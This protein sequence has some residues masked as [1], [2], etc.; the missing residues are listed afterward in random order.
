[1]ETDASDGGI[2]AVL[3]QEGHPIA[4][5]SK[6]LGP[7]SKG[8]STY[9]KE[10][11]A[12]LLAVEHWRS[13]LQ[14]QEFMILTDHHSLTHL[15]DQ[16]LHTPWQQKAFTKLLGLQYR[17]VY[18]K[19]SA[20]SAAD[21]LSRKDLGD[22]AQILAVSSCSPSWLQEVIQGYEQ[23]KFSSQLLA[24][25]SLNPKAREHYTLQQGLIRYKGRI[26]VGNNTDLQL[27]LIKELHDNPAGGHSGF[28]VTYRR[29]KH[30]FAWL[31]MKQQIQQQLKQCQIC[32]QAKPERVKYPGLLQPLPVPKGAWQVIS[33][34]FIE[35]LPTSDKYNCILVVV[36]KFSKYAHF[37]PLTHPFT[38][39]SVATVFMKNVYKLHGM[40]QVIISD[41]DRVFTSQLW[42]HLFTKSGTKL[43]MSSSYHP[44]TDGQTERVNRCLEIFLRC[45]IHVTPTKWANW[46]YLAEFWYNTSYHSSVHKTPFEVIYRY[47]PTHFGISMHDCEIPDLDLWLKDR[48]LI[49]QLIQQH[50]H[51][52]EQQMKAYAD[53]NRTFREFQ[54]GDW[55]YLKLQPYVQSSVARRANHKLSFKYFG[56]F[57]VLQRVGLVAYK[58]ALPPSCHIHLV[59]HVSQLKVARGY[60]PHVLSTEPFQWNHWQS[61]QQFLDRRITKKGTGLGA[62]RFPRKGE[63]QDKQGS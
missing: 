17:I 41:R 39:F 40:P 50:L 18:R 60:N 24:E 58:L 9:E 48:D 1:M 3:S 2:G 32:Q 30:L 45:F 11:M 22:S 56:P 14:H 33:M 35:G 55:V 47:Q 6:A 7:R 37:L 54:E 57:Q 36:D 43:H 38:A 34:D 15:S 10:C 16:R 12:I 42:E 51:Q 62:S 49:N 59:I 20:N 61:P 27:K 52:A 31:G 25:L 8:L 28:P 46:L 26:W 19:G 44:Q 29:I 23:D 4:Y 63:C 13:Y 53:K 21:A 5:L